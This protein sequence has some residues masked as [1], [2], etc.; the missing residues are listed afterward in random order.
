MV[1]SLLMGGS[2]LELNHKITGYGYTG[3]LLA[4]SFLVG[5]PAIAISSCTI[6]LQRSAYNEKI[7]PWQLYF[8][9][10]AGSIFALLIYP[11]VIENFISTTQFLTMWRFA[12]ILLSLGILKASFSFKN[13]NEN[14][15]IEEESPENLPSKAILKWLVLSAVASMC[16]SITS[17][18]IT[19]DV[20]S[21]PLL[22]ALPL[23][24]FL[25]AFSLPF[26][27]KPVLANI[28]GYAINSGLVV[29]FFLLL[30]RKYVPG[31]QIST[32]LYNLVLFFNVW[33]CVTGLV[34]SRPD[35]NKLQY[36]YT[37][38]ALGGLIGTALISIVCPLVFDSYLERYLIIPLVFLLPVLIEDRIKFIKDEY[39]HKVRK[40]I[41]IVAM[42]G[43]SIA[44]VQINE[45][46][47]SQGEKV[48]YPIHR[49]RSMY[50]VITVKEARQNDAILHRTLIHGN[51]LHG[52]QDMTNNTLDNTRPTTYYSLKSPLGLIYDLMLQR[53]KEM[54]VL[55][56]GLGAGTI[57][58]YSKPN[59]NTT[60]FE[61]DEEMVKIAKEYFSFLELNADKINIEVGD[62][63][64]LLEGKQDGS[65][66]IIIVDAFSSDSIPQHLITAEAV[67]L[68][69][70]K[71]KK[72]GILLIHTSNRYVRIEKIVKVIL[73][74][75]GYHSY[76]FNSPADADGYTSKWVIGS[77]EPVH[78]LEK[79]EELLIID[80]DGLRNKMW[81]DAYS[82]ILPYLR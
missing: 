10:N 59:I 74:S 65:Y 70:Q 37:M 13:Q 11:T 82:P 29:V 38:I 32:A 40:G 7:S 4:L 9:S 71:L 15:E 45:I 44:Y 54:E 20:A 77:K 41:I 35:P 27:P 79:R 76:I 46:D 81:T 39:W 43:V 80:T 21:I 17:S 66:S 48:Y 25:L 30:T 51:T 72:D 31:I 73:D 34:K 60:F 68:Y 42:L 69:L 58:Y 75:L 64:K 62:G 61:I 5:M 78:S 1:S 6:I 26:A 55:I 52:K 28:V 49:S 33:V 3:V 47:H 16:L 56:I 2:A 19:Q 36:F 53:E 12:L 67:L 57:N 23:A 50:G 8:Y 18:I 14:K 63:R 22:W 24:T